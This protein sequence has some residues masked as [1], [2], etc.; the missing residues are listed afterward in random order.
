MF[1]NNIVASHSFRCKKK[2]ICCAWSSNSKNVKK[3]FCD[4]LLSGSSICQVDTL[5]SHWKE[6]HWG[7]VCPRLACE[8]VVGHYLDYTDIGGH[9]H[10]GWH[11]C[12]WGDCLLCIWVKKASFAQACMHQFTPLCTV[13]RDTMWA[14]CLGLLSLC[15]PFK[16]EPVTLS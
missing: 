5:E 9:T 15:H 2:N 14:S 4:V 10:W 13:N 12:L 11:H 6:S 3:P 8:H 16:T 7:Y 1:S